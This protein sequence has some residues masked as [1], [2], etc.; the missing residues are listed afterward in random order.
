M[1]EKTILLL[2]WWRIYSSLLYVYAGLFNIELFFVLLCSKYL[3]RLSDHP[4]GEKPNQPL[5]HSPSRQ[6]IKKATT[7]ITSH[8]RFL[9]S[10]HL[11]MTKLVFSQKTGEKNCPK[12]QTAISPRISSKAEAILPLF[13][14]MSVTPETNRKWDDHK[15]CDQADM[16]QT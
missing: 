7:S 5:S 13:Q 9:E 11:N 3:S 16:L 15:A 1:D 14:S 2:D 10:F 12:L 8:R 4:A 6:K